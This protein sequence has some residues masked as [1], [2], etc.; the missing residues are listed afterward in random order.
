MI[1]SPK[2]EVVS[3]HFHPDKTLDALPIYNEDILRVNKQKRII[4]LYIC[5][6]MLYI[7]V[8]HVIYMYIKKI[9]SSSKP[10]KT[11]SDF[12]RTTKTAKLWCFSF[13]LG[14]KAALFP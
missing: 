3:H 4:T 7:V 6:N 10:F 5:N 14:F 11:H 2:V 9:Y 8:I 12:I 13:L 1:T